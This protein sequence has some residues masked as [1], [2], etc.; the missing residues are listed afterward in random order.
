MCACLELGQP[1]ASCQNNKTRDWAEL[2]LTLQIMFL[3]MTMTTTIMRVDVAIF[4]SL[5]PRH[6]DVIDLAYVFMH[7]GIYYFLNSPNWIIFGAM[8]SQRCRAISCAMV[9]DITKK[10]NHLYYL[11]DITTCSH[12]AIRYR[13]G[14]TID[15]TERQYHS[16]EMLS[17]S[18]TICDNI[19]FC[20]R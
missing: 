18:I 2:E 16:Q 14:I 11:K 17:I 15:K 9:G 1:C 19:M 5:G 12:R 20:Y 3:N 8:D 4:A 6:H 13:L 10:L 7:R